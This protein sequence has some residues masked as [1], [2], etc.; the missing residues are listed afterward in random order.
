MSNISLDYDA[1][2]HTPIAEKPFP[3]V[4]VPHFISNDDLQSIVA[5]L[6]DMQSGGSFPPEA[7]ELT[8][9]VNSMI[10]ELQG[11]L[12]KDQ[13][14]ENLGSDLAAAP[15]MMTDRGRTSDKDG[16]IHRV[17]EAK[18]VILLLYLNTGS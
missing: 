11:P 4:V 10:E 8:P 15:T 14:A 2:A 7:L 1:L 12:L 18:L 9:R 16:R 13:I 6:P 5:D 3:H 17:S